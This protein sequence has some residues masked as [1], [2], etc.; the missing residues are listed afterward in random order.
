MSGAIQG[1]LGILVFLAIAVAISENRSGIDKRIVAYGVAIHLVLAV[2][3][4]KVPF[5]R[6]IFDLLAA[7]VRELQVASVKG[8]SFI[9]GYLGGAPLPFTVDGP[10]DAYVMAFQTLPVLLIVGALS[11]ALWHWGVLRYAVRLA[12]HLVRRAF[13]VGGAVGVSS[14]ANIFMG[15]VEAPLLIRPYLIG[16]SRGELLAVMSTGMAT[17]AGTMMVLIGSVLE[18]RVANAFSHILI[19][20]VVNVP[21]A[22]TLARIIVPDVPEDD[23]EA[24]ALKTEYNGT[25]DAL[26]QGTASAVKLLANVV[27]MVVVFVALIALA[28]AI[29]GKLTSGLG[30]PLQLETI[31]SWVLAPFAWLIG[32]ESGDVK[33]AG[34]LL[35]TK[36]VINEIV[37]YL[38]LADASLVS[39]SERSMLLLTYAMCSFSNFGSL[40]IMIG[41]FSAMA[42][43]RIS[44]IAQLGPRAMV[45]GFL[46]GSST[47]A[48]MSV[49]FAVESLLGG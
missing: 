16:L 22:L 41:G 37:A 20:S 38:Q 25:M 12:A 33:A 7:G 17:I 14:A 34:S 44:E 46:A 6:G 3:L 45:A 36:I 8:T 28:N 19:A 26:A 40:A 43:S 42:P 24:I 32:I 39:L 21:I 4:Y 5:V 30:E 1:I 49:I 29:L 47:A 27:A 15:M 23:G 13:N 31:F 10:G 11:A 35:G 48:V 2:I 9:F 18:P